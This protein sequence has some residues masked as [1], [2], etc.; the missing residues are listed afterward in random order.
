MNT[1]P[2]RLAL[3]L[4]KNITPSSE[5]VIHLAQSS[6][7]NEKTLS[8]LRQ[9]ILTQKVV[10]QAYQNA[11]L[12][13]Q[14]QE[15][16]TLR[17]LITALQED[18]ERRQTFAEQ[19]MPKLRTEITHIFEQAKIR[20]LFIKGSSLEDYPHGY[21]RQM[22]D[23]DLMVQ[24]WDEC[25]RAAHLLEQ[26]GY[27]HSDPQESP[28]IENIVPA[29][30]LED[31]LVGHLNLM[32]PTE[33][34]HVGIDIHMAPF[35]VG[36]TGIL[37]CDLWQRAEGYQS[38]RPRVPTPE[39]QLL[40]LVA[41]ATN[42]GYVLIKDFNDC[43]AL[44]HRHNNTFDWDYFCRCIKQSMLSEVAY[45]VLK[46]VKEE[47]ASEYVPGTVLCMLKQD[48]N[49]I[50]AQTIAFTSEKVQQRR[51]LAEKAIQTLHTLSYERH[52]Y[53][54][55]SSLRVSLQFLWWSWCLSTL[56]NQESLGGIAFIRH[57][58]H[59]TK[60]H[61]F[62][63][64]PRGQQITILPITDICD[65]LTEEQLALCLRIPASLL[66]QLMTEREA[67]PPLEAKL[68]GSETLFVRQ[69]RA[70]VIFTSLDIFVPTQDGVFTEEEVAA[71]ETL[72]D[73]ILH[74]CSLATTL[75]G[76]L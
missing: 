52:K 34:Y 64:P 75:P 45:Y 7:W 3:A 72:M 42:H 19:I 63:V 39:D 1:M 74:V 44:L 61:I 70:E 50:Y 47:Y 37:A 32:L 76:T 58:L 54:L 38:V 31:R 10:L 15:I 69:G 9:K 24:S 14:Q 33:H 28:W 67:T 56:Q 35:T 21:M 12:L 26:Q 30:K 13:L 5:A 60:S 20:F 11:S 73:T 6:Y 49:M 41:H 23:I 17:D 55:A 16:K 59:T 66:F 25:F 4:G 46:R 48:R 22:N 57:L 62:P 8:E 40:I 65:H 53:G 36:P 18:K 43:Y 51:D 27:S 71:L 68:V 29:Q 2:T